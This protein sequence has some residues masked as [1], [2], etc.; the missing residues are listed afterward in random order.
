[1]EG[2][3]IAAV[4]D[5]CETVDI[6]D[7]DNDGALDVLAAKFQRHDPPGARDANDRRFSSASSTTSPGDGSQWQ[8]E[9]IA[10]DGVYAAVSARGQATP[11]IWTIGPRAVEGAHSLL[12]N[13]IADCR[14]PLD[15]GRISRS[16]VAPSSAIS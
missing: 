5:W 15:N 13:K 12:E 14:L 7:I 16:T 1:V 2:T 11:A 9:D 10:L 6:G 8:R 3:Q 4:F